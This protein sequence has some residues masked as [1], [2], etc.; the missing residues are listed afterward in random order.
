MNPSPNI[1]I[2]GASSTIAQAFS[3]LI[4]EKQNRLTRIS[5]NPEH[6]NIVVNGYRTEELSDLSQHID[7]PKEHIELYIFNGLLHGEDL[8]PEKS[9]E[10]W[11]ETDFLRVMSANTLAP[12]SIIQALWP[13]LIKAN[14]LKLV[15]LSARIGSIGDNK[16][17]GWMSYRSAKATLNQMIMCASIELHRRVRNCSCALYHPGT[18]ESPLSAPFAK[19]TTNP[20]LMTPAQSASALRAV[21]AKLKTSPRAQFID[22]QGLP[23]EW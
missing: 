14:Y 23:I 22:W 5:R 15:V 11:N 17:G 9:I 21:S 3:Q 1:I 16:L 7:G 18:T 4:D 20:K 12:M 10:Q 19:N 6:A 8:R 13:L 2:A